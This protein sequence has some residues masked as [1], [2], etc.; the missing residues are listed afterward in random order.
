MLVHFNLAIIFDTTVAR[1]LP[2]HINSDISP[3]LVKQLFTS[4]PC[5]TMQ[6]IL[7]TTYSSKTK[8]QNL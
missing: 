8:D 4:F 2:Y 7:S 6:W 3:L 1:I 5:H